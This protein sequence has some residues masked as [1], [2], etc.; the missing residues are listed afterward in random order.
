M[1]RT[2]A[3]FMRRSPD[4]MTEEL[5]VILSQRASFEFKPLYELVYA[6]LYV[7]RAVGGGDEMLRLRVYEKLQS[8]V[9]DGS[10]N[11][12]AKKYRGIPAR[13]LIVRSR[14]EECRAASDKRKSE[15]G[16]LV[17]RSFAAP[18]KKA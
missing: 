5:C 12:T 6:N 17:S 13:L 4:I 8:L 9:Y 11:K 2:T 18:A 3:G 7:R 10:V 14:L 1:K 16:Q 15:V